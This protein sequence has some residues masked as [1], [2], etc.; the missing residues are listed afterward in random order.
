MPS[1]LNDNCP[2]CSK[3]I[4]FMKCVNN[5]DG[6]KKGILLNQKFKFINKIENNYPSNHK[7]YLKILKFISFAIRLYNWADPR[8]SLQV[9]IQTRIL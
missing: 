8:S 2:F 7:S 6:I 4:I 1:F 5:P 9:W 3:T